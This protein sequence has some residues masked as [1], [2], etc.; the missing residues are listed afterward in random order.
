MARWG[1]KKLARQGHALQA[2][3]RCIVCD[4]WHLGSWTDVA[5]AKGGRLYA[6]FAQRRRNQGL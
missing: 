6:T 5:R 4:Q 3:Y 2:I 1:A